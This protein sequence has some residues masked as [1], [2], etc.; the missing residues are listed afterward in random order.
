MGVVRVRCW[1]D[2]WS[3]GVELV[4]IVVVRKYLFF[5]EEMRLRRGGSGMLL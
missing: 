1:E 3:I 4:F 2:I 5:Y